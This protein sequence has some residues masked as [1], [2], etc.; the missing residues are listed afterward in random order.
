M[1][2]IEIYKQY[3]NCDN[4]INKIQFISNLPIITELKI[5]INFINTIIN[6]DNKNNTN[7]EKLINH[8]YDCDLICT[9]LY[10]LLH[11]NN[12]YSINNIEHD[13]NIF[14]K[15]YYLKELYFLCNNIAE[16]K[17]LQY[18]NNFNLNNN[19]N[20]LNINNNNNNNNNLL[21]TYPLENNINKL[22][23]YIINYNVKQLYY[24]FN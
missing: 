15:Y 18:Y 3:L 21:D 20:S 2:G 14:D 1:Y 9:F 10:N 13:K 7:K 12:L 24:Y 17:K 4:N 23:V 11:K 6:L 19:I 22:D 16:N 8:I 5:N